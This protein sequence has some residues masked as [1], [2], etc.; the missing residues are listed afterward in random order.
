MKVTL[1]TNN[2]DAA[3]ALAVSMLSQGLDLD[4]MV[5]VASREPSLRDRLVKSVRGELSKIKQLITLDSTTG[6]TLRFE[7]RCATNAQKHLKRFIGQYDFKKISH[8]PTKVFS[9]INHP[10]LLEE[11]KH[12]PPETCM[13]YGTGIIKENL[14]QLA[15]KAFV[16]AHCSIL[17][18]YRGTRSEFWQCFH[19]DFDS[20][21]VTIHLVNSGVDTGE[22]LKQIP[23][24]NVEYFDPDWLRVSN[25]I[26]II[27]EFPK[28]V[29]AFI[30]GKIIP[31]AQ[32]RATHT[33]AYRFKDITL[34]KRLTVYE[35]IRK[36]RK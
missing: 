8:I 34:E 31:T 29:K 36:Q 22:L 20:L 9:S 3:K 35:R 13:V 16:N 33:R 25:T 21:G 7:R 23:L 32:D 19:D 12:T 26:N 5:V 30:E 4:R 27:E 2:T 17:P 18:D 11:F 6:K 14:L 10:Q 24:T 1:L 15:K 28:I